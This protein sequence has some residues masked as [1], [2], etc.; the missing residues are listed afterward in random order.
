MVHKSLY[1]EGKKFE[2]ASKYKMKYESDIVDVWD[3]AV[4]KQTTES[5]AMKQC[6]AILGPWSTSSSNWI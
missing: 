4:T 5:G 6:L 1:V 2:E 3:V